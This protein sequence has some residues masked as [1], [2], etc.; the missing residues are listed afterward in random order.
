MW[1]LDVRI[2]CLLVLII[3]C[4]FMVEQ[5]YFL[6]KAIIALFDKYSISD[7]IISVFVIYP[8]E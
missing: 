5:E 6:I 1:K 7:Q 8:T 3:F 2:K 4:N